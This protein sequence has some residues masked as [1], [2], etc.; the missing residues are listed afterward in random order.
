MPS[1]LFFVR[2]FILIFWLINL[3]GSGKDGPVIVPTSDGAEGLSRALSFSRLQLATCGQEAQRPSSLRVPIHVDDGEAGDGEEEAVCAL[4]KRESSCELALSPITPITT[5][6]VGLSKVLEPANRLRPDQIIEFERR[7]PELFVVMEHFVAAVKAEQI[8]ICTQIQALKDET[9]ARCHAILKDA[10]HW[11]TLPCSDV[12]MGGYDDFSLVRVMYSYLNNPELA[13]RRCLNAPQN[14]TR[15]ARQSLF[16]MEE[17]ALRSFS[18]AGY[19]IVEPEA[20][21]ETIAEDPSIIFL[22]D[23]L[24]L[25][26][27]GSARIRTD[28]QT[29][30]HELEAIISD[31]ADQE[32]TAK[33]TLSRLFASYKIPRAKGSLTSVAIVEMLISYIDDPRLA[34]NFYFKPDVLADT[35]SFK[36]QLVDAIKFG[37]SNMIEIQ[38][39]RNK[40]RDKTFQPTVTHSD[41]GAF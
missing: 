1:F 17:E 24:A 29:V 27:L 16:S 33:S 32:T 41:D 38:R 25:L 19:S 23:S 7:H 35:E 5:V 12:T 4:V 8:R 11:G 13:L 20:V 9:E 40:L 30:K 34:L 31:I 21:V 39:L 18:S 36:L 14:D 10:F 26:D 15:T 3:H 2:L 6:G 37:V 28:L 22:G